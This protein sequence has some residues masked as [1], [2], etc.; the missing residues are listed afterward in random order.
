MKFLRWLIPACM[1]SLAIDGWISYRNQT[2]GGWDINPL[3]LFALFILFASSF[4]FHSK[5]KEKENPA[6]RL[7]CLDRLRVLAVFLV[8][9]VHTFDMGASLAA[10]S[11]MAYRLLSLGSVLALVC[12]PIYIMLSGALLLGRKTSGLISFYRKRFLTTAVPLFAY[13]LIYKAVHGGIQNLYPR[14]LPGLLIEIFRGPF[15]GAP[16]FWLIYT[17]LSLYLAAPFLSAMLVHLPAGLKKGLVVMIFLSQAA[18][19]YLPGLHLTSQIRFLFSGW[20]GVFLLGNLLMDPDF[21]TWRKPVA[22]AGV[23]GAAVTAA[24]AFL[25]WDTAMF[26]NTAPTM[27]LMA[28]AIFV[29]F[30]EMEGRFSVPGKW[31][32]LVS[33]HS[34]SVILI[35]WYVLYYLVGDRFF[36]WGVTGSFGWIITVPAVFLLSLLLAICYDYVVV[37]LLHRILSYLTVPPKGLQ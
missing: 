36:T 15:E 14:N 2:A 16:H 4:Y 23:A 25:D 10:K 20:T 30:L 32:L 37:F 19:T 1:A 21:K 6:G 24:A 9:G 11:S 29:G 33:R 8:I 7:K 28:A 26:V 34:Y 27:T 13:Y 18:G 12:N 31:F 17:I 5:E 35:H 3:R 22:G